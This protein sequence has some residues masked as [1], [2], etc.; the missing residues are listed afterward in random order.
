MANLYVIKNDEDIKVVFTVVKIYEETDTEYIVDTD[1]GDLIR[2]TGFKFPKDKI[3]VRLP[4]G[5][6]TNDINNKQLEKQLK[7]F[8]EYLDEN[9]DDYIKKHTMYKEINDSWYNTSIEKI[10]ELRN[11][12]NL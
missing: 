1:L 9:H 2:G 4:K 5:F 8:Y 6:V 12:N 3:N 7:N 10:T 11:K